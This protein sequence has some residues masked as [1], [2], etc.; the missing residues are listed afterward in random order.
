[1]KRKL[2]VLSVS[3]LL[4]G[5]VYSQGIFKAAQT[6]DVKGLKALVSAGNI[7]SRDAHGNTALMMAVKNDR[8]EAT[9]VLVDRNA[10]LNIQDNSGNT[11]LII[12]C[13]SGKAAEI[14][15]LLDR[16]AD[17]NIQNR[18]GQTALLAAVINGQ[19]EAVKALLSHNAQANIADNQHKTAFDYA[20]NLRSTDILNLLNMAQVSAQQPR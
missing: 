6:N 12:A 1:M 2:I 17:V 15:I 19:L 18:N 16:F 5:S 14:S 3:V 4:S 13:A 10:N 8:K 9:T 20:K 7:N 11:A